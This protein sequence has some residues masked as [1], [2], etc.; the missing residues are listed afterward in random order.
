MPKPSKQSLMVLAFA[1][2]LSSA[3]AQNG[4]GGPGGG[5]GGGQGGRPGM[6]QQQREQMQKYRPVFDLISTVNLMLEVDKQKGLTFT[7]AQAKLA[8]P[9]LKDLAGRTNLPPKDAEAI[10]A[11]LED[12]LMTEK[13][14]AWMDDFRLKRDEER[15][16]RFQQQGGN[17]QQGGPSIRIPGAG[18]VGGQNRQGGPGGG[19]GA[20]FQAIMQGKPFNPFKD[21]PGAEDIKTL[22]VLLTKRADQA[23]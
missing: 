23:T 18:Q 2:I 12:K 1:A 10:L 16:K 17:N 19:R 22:T 7:K 13:Q 20:M 5:P 4:P 11:K 21:G 14:V 15:R 9:I 6:T 3:L 8:L